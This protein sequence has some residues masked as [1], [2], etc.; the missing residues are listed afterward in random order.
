MAELDQ[1]PF[2]T[3]KIIDSSPTGW[4]HPRHRATNIDPT[5]DDDQDEGYWYGSFW[6]N[7]DGP[8]IFVCI[9]P[10]T[11]AADWYRFV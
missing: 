4:N 2:I 9:D 11:G 7:I 10:A 6:V 8:R 3:N 5:A 1:K